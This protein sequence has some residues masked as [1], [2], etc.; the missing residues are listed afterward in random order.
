MNSYINTLEY[1]VIALLIPILILSFLKAA[2]SSKNS[3]KEVLLFK[4]KMS[5]L[6]LRL[7]F[8]NYNV[9]FKVVHMQDAYVSY[10]ML[11]INV[12]WRNIHWFYSN[13]EITDMYMSVFYKFIIKYVALEYKGYFVNTFTEL[14]QIF[15]KVVYITDCIRV[16]IH[17]FLDL[18]CYPM[19]YLF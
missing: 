18:F 3:T 6:R 4:S 7:K 17:L 16:N 11:C 15:K 13:I 19:L 2:F 5:S 12:S 9:Y 14:R 8:S 10:M 1:A